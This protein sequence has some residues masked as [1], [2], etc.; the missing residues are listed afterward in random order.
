MYLTEV[1]SRCSC[2]GCN[3]SHLQ[4]SKEIDSY[5][6]LANFSEHLQRFIYDII[7]K[8]KSCLFNIIKFI[9]KLLTEKTNCCL[10]FNI[11]LH[12]TATFMFFI[13]IVGVLNY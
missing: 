8:R 10:L 4:Y 11:P 3:Y 12:S 13:S 2:C 5:F 9:S 7:E 6:S 1:F